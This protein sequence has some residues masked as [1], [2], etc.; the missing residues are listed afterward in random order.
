MKKKANPTPKKNS[1][2]KKKVA[3]A[4]VK[5]KPIILITKMISDGPYKQK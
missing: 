4:S 2:V 3:K 1:P 5:E